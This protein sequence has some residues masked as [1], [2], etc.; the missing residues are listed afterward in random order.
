MRTVFFANAPCRP[1]NVTNSFVPMTRADVDDV[2]RAAAEYRRLIEIGVHWL[3]SPWAALR[4]TRGWR[5]ETP[6]CH[7]AL[8]ISK[9][10]T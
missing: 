9:R 10:L 5:T 7:L 2:E 8:K 3:I 4:K 1:S 6:R